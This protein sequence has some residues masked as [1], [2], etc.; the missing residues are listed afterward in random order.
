MTMKKKTT[1][2][3]VEYYSLTIF[4][5]PLIFQS[6]KNHNFAKLLN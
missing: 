3:I 5:K 1:H 4:S 6:S 2:K